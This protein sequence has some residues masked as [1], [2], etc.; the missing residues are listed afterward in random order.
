MV[1]YT[2]I[3]IA[4]NKT[5]LVQNR[6]E[7]LLPDDAYPILQNA[8]V[9]REKVV[10]KKGVEKIGRLQRNIDATGLTLSLLT[11][12]ET[13]SSIAPGTIDIFG[14]GGN[15]WL[16][17]DPVDGTIINQ[18]TAA[19]GTINYAT[20][21]ITGP[22][23]P[24]SGGTFGYY[25]GLPVMGCLSRELNA[26]NDEETIFFDTKYAYRYNGTTHQFEEFIPGTTW[27]GT[28]Y[29]FFWSTNYW[30]SAP[31]VVGP[32]LPNSKLFWVTNFSGVSG[33]PIRYTEGISWVDFAPT[34]NAAG[35]KLNQCLAMVPY[36]GRMVAFR[37][38][39]GPNLSGS[40]ENFQRIRWSAIGNPISDVSVLFPIGTVNANAWRDDIRGQ[41]GFLDIPTSQA[42]TAIGFVRDNLVIYCERSTWQL[43]YTGRSI[44]PFQ[45]ERVNA[46]LGTESTFS[47]IQFDTSLVGIG[48]KGIVQCDSYQSTPIDIKIPNLVFGIQNN[49]QGT[50]RVYGAR[51]YENRLAYWIYPGTY[52]GN[53]TD[54]ENLLKFP[55]L[56]LVY[57]YENDSWAIFE[58]S[59]T[60]LGTLQFISPLSW[61]SPSIKN[62]SWQEA[63]FPWFEDPGLFPYLCAGNQQGYI[64]L[65]D[66]FTSNQESLSITNIVGSDPAITVINCIDHNLNNTQVISIVNIMAA[67]PYV[68]LNNGVYGIN[69]I[70]KDNFEIFT[71]DST[72]QDFDVPVSN[73]AG[74]YLGLGEIRVRDGFT[75]QSK[76]FNFLND[77]NNIQLGFVDILVDQTANG[78]FTMNVYADYNNSNPINT[79]PQNSN[80]ITNA[81]DTFFN[82]I[83][84]TN[85]AILNA[86]SLQNWV[87]IYCPSRGGFLTTEFTLSNAQ[88]NGNEQESDVQI[89]AQ[90]M[91]VRKAGRQLPIGV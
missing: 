86:N 70:D 39:E 19:V 72:S 63:N 52:D 22:G 65:I 29:N 91:W 6:E 43:R 49:N 56:R 4:G 87:R 78:A 42:I 16:E 26:N 76:K 21:V 18:T 15:E 9:F 11:G 5:G 75:I 45:I 1:Q 8:Y 36:R 61:D 62:V 89:H 35:D 41:G 44:A 27:T 14:A 24:L 79:H 82:S 33:D 46:E 30:I 67:D 7:H 77:G 34:I 64:F 31:T 32:N 69:V 38:L 28:D 80:P 48:D 12:L 20:G 66:R 13:T 23:A 53:R 57:N 51:Y 68:T 10:R 73:P 55:N 2:P 83:V 50:N 59:F 74:T 37:T 85:N 71:Y 60:A 90:V 3:K 54:D 58:D 88:L 81:P 25:P 84:P 40:V 47:A 17:A